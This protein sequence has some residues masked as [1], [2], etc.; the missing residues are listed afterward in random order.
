MA[1]LYYQVLQVVSTRNVRTKESRKE[2]SGKN[3]LNL[4][5]CV[6]LPRPR[7]GDT[8]ATVIACLQ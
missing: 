1:E 4:A 5:K 7:A 3:Q 8:N 6:R 2:E